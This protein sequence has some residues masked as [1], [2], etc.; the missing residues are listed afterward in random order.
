MEGILTGFTM[1]LLKVNFSE[2]YD[3][4]LCRHSQFGIN[5]IHILA[6][7]GI[8][9]CLYSIVYRLVGI[10]WLLIGIAGVHLAILALNVPLKVLGSTFAFLATVIALIVS[11]P[12]LPAWTYALAIYPFYKI[13]A[14]SHKV[15]NVERDMTEFN[16]KYRKGFVLFVLLSVYEVPILLNY[17]VFDKNNWPVWLS[18]ARRPTQPV[19]ASGTP[20]GRAPQCP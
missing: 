9:L 1:N 6:V 12:T 16:K 10:E 7:L 3:R 17:L 11:L 4:H 19:Q 14:W 18:P 5:V 20:D 15:Y 8:Y 2:L 13:Q